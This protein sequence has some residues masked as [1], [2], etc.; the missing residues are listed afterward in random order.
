[1]VVSIST[2]LGALGPVGRRGSGRLLVGNPKR[3]AGERR[4]ASTTPRRCRV[5]VG[6]GL[7]T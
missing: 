4:G 6:G 3:A 2:G 5:G 7:Y 1:M